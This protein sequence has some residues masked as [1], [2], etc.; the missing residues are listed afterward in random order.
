MWI[1]ILIGWET[2]KTL[3][4]SKLL[5]YLKGKWAVHKPTDVGGYERMTSSGSE[6]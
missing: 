5:I 1:F 6:C 4:L 2:F 3:I